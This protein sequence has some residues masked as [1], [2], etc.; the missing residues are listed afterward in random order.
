MRILFAILISIL[1][2]VGIADDDCHHQPMV[3]RSRP[4]IERLRLQVV[5]PE[6]LA[7]TKF[8]ATV[9]AERHAGIVFLLSEDG[10]A[11][12]LKEG[13]KGLRRVA[14]SSLTGLHLLACRE[15]SSTIF[16]ITETGF[17]TEFA[18]LN[19]PA[20]G[21]AVD[22]AGRVWTADQR[23]G[24]I[25]LIDVEGQNRTIAEFGRRVMDIAADDQGAYVL[26]E[27]GIVTSVG[28]DGSTMK[29]GYVGKG[30]ARIQI[31][32]D[33]SVVALV[34][35]ASGQCSLREPLDDDPNGRHIGTVPMG[36]SAFAFDRLNN[37]TLANPDLKAV[38]R[39]T[40]HFRVP[41]PHCGKPVDMTLDP[42]APRRPGQPQRRS[43]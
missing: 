37:L 15:S 20:T 39:V 24:R 29:V 28:V 7:I 33:H 23:T 9:V 40:S 38:T 32:A 21:L 43:F 27:D 6:D 41:C 4:V 17:S 14:D 18:E 30:A 8:G 12:I 42:K 1:P 13:V 34:K 11:S 25:I 5:H 2:S 36:T 22:G 3:V 16:K 35:D 19:F 31:R 10:E 26:S